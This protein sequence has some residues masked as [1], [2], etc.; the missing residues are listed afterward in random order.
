VCEKKGV[1]ALKL[2]RIRNEG[3]S[4]ILFRA[5]LTFGSRPSGP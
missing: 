1:Q 5:G 2:T 4:R 3:F